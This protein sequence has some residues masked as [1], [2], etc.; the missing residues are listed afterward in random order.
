MAQTPK[1]PKCPACGS[2]NVKLN[3]EDGIQSYRCDQGHTFF[4]KKKAS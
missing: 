1:P 3:Y 4:V 2:P